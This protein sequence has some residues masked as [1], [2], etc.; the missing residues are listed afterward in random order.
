MKKLKVG[1]IGLGQRGYGLL[2][3]VMVKLPTIEVTAVCD[4]YPDRMQ[5][6]IETINKTG[7]H[8]VTAYSD[9]NELI[10]SSGI[11]AVIVSS[12]WESHASIAVKTMEAGIPTGMEVGGAYTVE[13]C[14]DLVNTHE[15]TNT[16][17]MFL[18][19][20]CFD[21]TELMATF[22]ARA[23]LFGEVVYCSGAYSHDLRSEI[24]NGVELRHYR[25]RNYLSRN[26][27]NYPTHELGPIA[28]IL[29]INRG[30]RMLSVVSVASKAAGLKSYIESQGDKYAHLR[31]KD[32]RQGDI[33]NTIITCAG[34]QTISLLLDTTLPGFY[35]RALIVK[36]TKGMYNQ[37]ANMTILDSDGHIEHWTAAD[38]IKEMT[39]NAVKHEEQYLPSFWRNV[40][41]EEKQ[42]GHGGMDGF[43]L[44]IFFNNVRDGKEMPVDVYDAAAWMCITALSEQSIA[45]G[46]A[47]VSIPDF[48]RGKWLLRPSADVVELD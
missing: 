22:M 47:P 37:T 28:K 10:A 29:D 24:S 5:R 6:A 31:G 23:G 1:I 4:L 19:N 32:F 11:D 35:D 43:M 13:E 33:V 20:C 12:A 36:G 40:T 34:G 42:T 39:N 27:E 8:K 3:S 38:T 44:N 16:P 26:C 7:S 21:K 46:S 30:N 9:F 48:T 25:L 18:E 41:E 14:W 15:R 2:S 45:Q 17:F